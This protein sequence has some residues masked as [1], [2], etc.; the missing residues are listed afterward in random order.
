[1]EEVEEVEKEE[2]VEEADGHRERKGEKVGLERM[3]V[4]GAGWMV[5]QCRNIQ[6]C[7]L[8]AQ[9]GEGCSIMLQSLNALSLRCLYGN[10]AKKIF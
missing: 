2:E 5:V 8:G 9:G 6:T 1:V 7:S 4:W 10:C 3:E